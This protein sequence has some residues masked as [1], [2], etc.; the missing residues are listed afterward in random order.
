MRLALTI[1]C[2]EL[3]EAVMPTQHQ[4]LQVALKQIVQ[5]GSLEDSMRI[6]LLAQIVNLSLAI[7]NQN[8]SQRLK[9]N[10]AICRVNN[11]YSWLLTVSS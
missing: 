9:K 5:T 2:L 6:A 1:V 11:C 8:N 10:Q 3:E 7:H 4:K